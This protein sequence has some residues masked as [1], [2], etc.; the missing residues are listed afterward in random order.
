ML[1]VVM[2]VLVAEE[3]EV[4]E[5]WYVRITGMLEAG[6]PAVVSRTWHVIGGL[7]ASLAM[8]AAVAGG[9]GELESCDERA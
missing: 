1:A 8:F 6:F 3:A 4:G 7:T 9:L 5:G 2:V